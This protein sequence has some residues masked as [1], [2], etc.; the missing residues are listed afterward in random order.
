MAHYPAVFLERLSEDENVVHVNNHHPLIN[1]LF[2]QLIHHSLECGGTVAQSKEN[3]KWLEQSPV[4]SK[5][6]LPLVAVFDPNIIIPPADIE[7]GKVF[8]PRHLTHEVRDQWEWV[9]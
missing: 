6:C 5:C 3:D 8:C 1:E 4:G 2:E 9:S 7:L